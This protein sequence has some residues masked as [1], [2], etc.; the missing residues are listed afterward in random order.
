M[1]WNRV[2]LE[3]LNKDYLSGFYGFIPRNVAAEAKRANKTS[4]RKRKE[5]MKVYHLGNKH[6]KLYFTQREAECMLNLIKGRTISTTATALEL[7]ARTVE[8]YVNN[9][10]RKLDCRT[11]SDLIQKV[12]ETDF[13]QNVDFNI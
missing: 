2:L 7:S 10:K 12:L 13:M 9:M 8:F 6:P 5:Q 11:K 1:Y 3:V 4:G